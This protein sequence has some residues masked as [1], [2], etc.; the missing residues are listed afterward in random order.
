MTK[1][2]STEFVFP[3]YIVLDDDDYYLTDSLKEATDL[4]EDQF[5]EAKNVLYDRDIIDDVKQFIPVINQFE[6]QEQTRIHLN[7]NEDTVWVLLPNGT[8]G[9]LV[10]LLRTDILTDENRQAINDE[11]AD[12]INDRNFMQFMEQFNNESQLGDD[13]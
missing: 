5:R 10:D 11:L 3:K 8:H 9:P 13:I 6:P 2:Y 4:T 1:Y 7:D 12:I